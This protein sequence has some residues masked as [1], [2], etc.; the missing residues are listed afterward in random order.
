MQ[1]N[2]HFDMLRIY[3]WAT[4]TMQGQ[5]KNPIRHGVQEGLP[6]LWQ[7]KRVPK[8]QHHSGTRNQNHIRDLRRACA[9]CMVTETVA[10]H[11]PCT[12]QAWAP[13]EHAVTSQTRKW[14]ESKQQAKRKLPGIQNP[15]A[16]R[17]EGDDSSGP[18]PRSAH[19]HNVATTALKPQHP[20][21]G[22]QGEWVRLSTVRDRV[23]A[24]ACTN[25]VVH[26]RLRG[27]QAMAPR[28]GQTTT[29]SNKR[30]KMTANQ[31]SNPKLKG[32][33]RTSQNSDRT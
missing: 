16:E 22:N 20:K 6:G 2:A 17:W 24:A 9:Q 13:E 27:H 7:P 30:S 4:G 8:A 15:T 12:G 25:P 31:A 18:R 1:T 33:T 32:Q 10:H 11:V 3:P 5:K 14:R 28:A 19:T 29:D 23:P 26:G 21:N